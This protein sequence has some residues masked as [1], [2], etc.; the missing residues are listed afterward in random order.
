[1]QR[2]GIYGPF[3]VI[4]PL[5]TIA[6]W[7]REFESWSDFNVVIYH[8]SIY[9]R[10]LINEYELYYRDASGKVITDAFKFNVIVTTY[11]VMLGG[12]TCIRNS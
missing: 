8:G 6:N 11:E 7:Q 9:S 3:L 5:S 2:A 12:Y 4:A 10:R 1:M